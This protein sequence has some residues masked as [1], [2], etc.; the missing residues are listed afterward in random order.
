MNSD[1]SLIRDRPPMGLWATPLA[2]LFEIAARTRL[3]GFDKNYLKSVH[4]G[5]FTVSIG[6]IEAGGTGKTPWAEYILR[7][8]S[9]AGK[10]PGLLSR[11]YGRSAKGLVVRQKG[12]AAF[13]HLIGDEPAMIVNSGL[14]I[15]VAAVSKRV[16]GAAALVQAGC[17]TIVLDDG[18]SHRWL[19]RDVDILVMRGEAPLGSGYFLPRGTLREPVES[20][21]RAHILVLHFRDSI[22]SENV[23]GNIRA[24]KSRWPDKKL[25]VS[26]LKVRGKRLDGA[27]V[28]VACAVARPEGVIRS[29]E[30]LGGRVLGSRFYADHHR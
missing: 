14:D 20:V 2:Y 29:V 4:P 28:F 10:N 23:S 6:G 8:F 26:T 9:E 25:V 19:R 27:G 17:D 16:E 18:F 3:Q 24:I 12:E 30:K 22:L 11:G 1:V 15:P 7:T 13:P 5:V 21:Q